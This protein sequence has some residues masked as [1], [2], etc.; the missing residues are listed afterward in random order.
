[1][2]R[3]NPNWRYRRIQ[4]E[5]LKLGHRLAASAIR[6]IRKRQPPVGPRRGETGSAPPTVGE[7]VERLSG[8]G[9]RRHCGANSSHS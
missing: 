9:E 8:L 7:D 5:L 2:A 4:G 6:R 1:M 3:E